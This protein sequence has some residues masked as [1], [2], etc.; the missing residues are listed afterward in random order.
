[1]EDNKTVPRSPSQC[2]HRPVLGPWLGLMFRLRLSHEA[3]EWEEAVGAA[4]VSAELTQSSSLVHWGH[5]R[6][7]LEIDVVTE[8]Q[9]RFSDDGMCF[10]LIWSK[11]QQPPCSHSPVT[12]PEIGVTERDMGRYYQSVNQ[13]SPKMGVPQLLGEH[14][15]LGPEYN[16]RSEFGE[17]A[18][19]D[20]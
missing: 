17:L 1:M 7:S 18:H 19:C 20:G 4:P 16:L 6:P 5:M 13:T 15:W 8:S 3:A 12:I 2:W 9:F 14:F 10:V 11:W